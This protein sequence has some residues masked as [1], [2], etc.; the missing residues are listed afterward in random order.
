[1]VEPQNVREFTWC[2]S[3]N[4][5]DKVNGSFE[6]RKEGKSGVV[7]TEKRNVQRDWKVASGPRVL[8]SGEMKELKR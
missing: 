2:E 1:M 4:V 3:K 8:R 7:S 5:Y 6:L